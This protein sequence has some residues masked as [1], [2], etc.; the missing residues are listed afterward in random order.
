[1]DAGDQGAVSMEVPAD[2]YVFAAVLD[3]FFWDSERDIKG[4]RFGDVAVHKNDTFESLGCQENALLRV[5]YRQ[6]VTVHP[7]FS[8][9]TTDSPVAKQKIEPAEIQ[10]TP[11]DWLWHAV[12]RAV[13]TEDGWVVDTVVASGRLIK[14]DDVDAW[15]GALDIEDGAAIS[16][17]MRPHA[18]SG[19]VGNDAQ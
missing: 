7:T 17:T 19:V 13:S 8:Y 3:C 18:A 9:V 2:E 4:V 12:D 5:T 10:M 16:V 11:N 15:V 6:T 14:N 1:M